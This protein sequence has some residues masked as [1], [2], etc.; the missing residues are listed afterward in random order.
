MGT[1]TWGGGGYFFFYNSITNNDIVKVDDEYVIIQ[2]DY[3][4]HDLYG[5]EGETVHLEGRFGSGGK[6]KQPSDD[7]YINGRW[8]GADKIVII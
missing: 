7:G 8:F 2:G 5:H 3:L 4:S 1:T 6:S